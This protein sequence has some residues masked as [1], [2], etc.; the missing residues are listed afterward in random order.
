L[1]DIEPLR[2]KRAALESGAAEAVREAQLLEEERLKSESAKRA[3]ARKVAAQNVMS[4]IKDKLPFLTNA[5]GLDLAAVEA[6]ASA[7]DPAVLHPVDLAYNATAGQLLP[8][9]ARQFLAMRKEVES[10][11]ARLAEYDDAEPRTPGSGRVNPGSGSKAGAELTFEE[12][13]QQRLASMGV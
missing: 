2:A 10:L 6:K 13:I 11:T 4:R 9:M 12:A 1:E 5:E 8:V 3:N 7:V